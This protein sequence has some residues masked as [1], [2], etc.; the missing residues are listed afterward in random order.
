VLNKSQYDLNQKV[1]TQEHASGCAVAC[2]AFVLE[3]PYSKAIKLFKKP[4]RALSSGFTC[5]DIVQALA[6]KSKV[7]AYASL[8]SKNQ[9]LLNEAGVIV[10]IRRSKFYP[11]G[12]F[13]V[14]SNR[15]WMNPWANYPKIAPAQGALQSRL[16]GQAIYVIY[17]L[18]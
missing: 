16:P 12:H 10:F 3:I 13:L 14:R 2:V 15:T 7:Y 1:V 18:S 6:K 5:K 9:L 4:S 17:P 11:I 8:N